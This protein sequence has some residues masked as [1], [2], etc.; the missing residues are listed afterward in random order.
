ML[1]FTE[2]PL[3]KATHVEKLWTYTLNTMIKRFIN[4]EFGNNLSFGPVIY[5]LSLFWFISVEELGG[6]TLRRVFFSYIMSGT[7]PFWRFLFREGVMLELTENDAVS[8]F[9]AKEL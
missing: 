5:F 1:Y 6:H 8:V 2:L 9:L 4:E 7:Y 3:S